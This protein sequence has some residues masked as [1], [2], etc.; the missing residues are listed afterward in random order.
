MSFMQPQ[1]VETSAETIQPQED[2][3]TITSSGSLGGKS[4]VSQYGR[5]LHEFDDDD[6]A[7]AW[8]RQDMDINEYWPNV[9]IVSDHGNYHLHMSEK[10]EFSGISWRLSAPGYMDCTDWTQS[11]S[12]QEAIVDMLGMFGDGFDESDLQSI[13]SELEGFADF[14]D[15]YLIGLAFTGSVYT[16]DENASSEDPIYSNPG[17]EI[18]DVVDAEE[19]FAILSTDERLTIL[20]DCICFLCSAAEY[21]GES[22]DY[23]GAGSDFHLTRNGHGAGFWDGDW[24][25]GNKLTELSKP[26]GTAELAKFGDTLTIQN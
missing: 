22:P 2:D 8:I 19:L 24:E 9:W 25:N 10:T 5:H 26:Y 4:S 16:D 18:A 7:L 3:Y 21:L 20:T 15:G 6:D 11:E 23:S 1:F 14:L 17:G 12:L 13:G